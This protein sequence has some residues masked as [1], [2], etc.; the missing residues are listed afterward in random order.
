[1][2]KVVYSDKHRGHAPP[3]QL[4]SD[5]LHPASEVPERVERIVAE[6]RVRQIGDVIIPREFSLDAISA[7]HDAGLLRFLEGAYTAWDEKGRA[8]ETGL[9]PDTFAMRTLEGKPEDLVR[10]VGYYCF[11]T[12]TPIVA[13][14]WDAAREAA[15]C[16]LT[17]ADL[18]LEGE[19]AVYALC[20]PPGHH[21]A[22]D[23]YGG[24]CYLNNAA[25][26]AN[27]L[28]K[29]GRVTILDVDYHHGNGTQAIFY[30]S[31]VV[32]FVSLHADPNSVYPFY[33]GYATEKGEG[34]G[35]GKTC[36]FPLPKGTNDLM[37]LDA[38]DRAL[39]VIADFS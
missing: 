4:F 2:M 38:L 13:G 12:Q 14:T 7:V 23:L 17:G 20:R 10:Q 5:G 36:N 3:C 34:A 29:L 22:R 32:Q 39:S 28:S 26:A 6:I 11:E 30:A 21:A 16:A 18:I 24:Y 8:T 27:H 19:Q 25:V 37:Y 35:E 9:I 33:S 15:G 1:M 31:D